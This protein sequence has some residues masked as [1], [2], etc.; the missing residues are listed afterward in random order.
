MKKLLLK[1]EQ[2][3]AEKKEWT[4]GIH[5]F[6]NERIISRINVKLQ[7]NFSTERIIVAVSTKSQLQLVRAF[8]ALG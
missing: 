3:S 1:N 7:G 8:I 5:L 2:Q 6:S 4:P